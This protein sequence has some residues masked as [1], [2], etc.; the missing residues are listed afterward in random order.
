M[1]KYNI[2][3]KE[4]VNQIISLSSVTNNHYHHY[5]AGFLE[6]RYVT[7]PMQLEQPDYVNPHL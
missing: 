2:G 5:S 4:L 1:D 6:I 3:H 7:L